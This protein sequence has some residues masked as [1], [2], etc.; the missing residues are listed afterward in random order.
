M[1]RRPESVRGSVASGCFKVMTT[2]VAFGLVTEARAASLVSAPGHLFETACCNDHTTLAA[3]RVWPLANRSPLRSVKVRVSPSSEVFQDEARPA[4]MPLSLLQPSSVS[5]TFPIST[6]SSEALFTVRI[7]S[8]SG[9]S[10]TP[11]A[12]VPVDAPSVTLNRLRCMIR[13]AAT[14]RIRASTAETPR[15]ISQRV[16]WFAVDC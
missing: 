5:Y 14:S 3:S 10:V 15:N 1:P 7:S 11:T 2:V 8:V 16:S 4:V 12:S 6:R 13:G 9:T